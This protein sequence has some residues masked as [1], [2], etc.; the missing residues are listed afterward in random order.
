LPLGKEQ[1][2]LLD[3]SPHGPAIL[4]PLDKEHCWDSSFDHRSP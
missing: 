2:Q 3:A 1:A 4:A